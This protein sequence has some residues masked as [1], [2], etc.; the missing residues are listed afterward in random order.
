MSAATNIIIVSK[1]QE[2]EAWGSLTEICRVYG[3]SYNYLKTKKMPFEYRGVRINRV[4]FRAK[5]RDLEADP[6]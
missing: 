4:P 2:Q 3:W 6:K 5:N 1:D